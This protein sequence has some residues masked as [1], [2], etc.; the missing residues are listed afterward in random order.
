M[1]HLFLRMVCR[2]CT[3]IFMILSCGNTGSSQTIRHTYRFNDNL[4]VSPPECGPVL[5]PLRSAGNCNAAAGGGAFTDDNV[6]LCGVT[7]KVYQNNLHWGLS[8]PNTNGTITDNYTIQMYVKNISWGSA[9]WSRII[10]FSN[11]SSD[12]GIYYKI[13]SATERCLDFYPSG[14]RGTCP[15]FKLDTYYLLTFTRNGTTGII[16]VYVNNTK[17]VSYPDNS[18]RYVGTS[19]VPILIYRD[20]AAV[21]CESAA[22]NFA[23]LSFST[24]YSSQATVDRDYNGICSIA[25]APDAANFKIEQPDLCNAANDLTV[26]YTGGISSQATGY[27]FNWD[28]HGGTEVSANGF[29]QYVVRYPDKGIKTVTLN[30]RN[31]PCGTTESKSQ[32]FEIKDGK[33]TTSVSQT[34]CAGTSY[35][36]YNSSGIY[37]DSFKTTGGC[38]SIRV[39]TLTALS[40]LTTTI[41]STICPGQNVNGYNSS[42]IYTDVFRLANG[43]DSTRILKL[44]VINPGTTSLGPDRSICIGDTI[45]LSANI[46]GKFEWQDGSTGNNFIVSKPGT[47]WL[48]VTTPCGTSRD[49]VMISES[50]CVTAFP[51]GFTPNGD[52]KNDVFRMVNPGNP[53]SFLLQIYN[54]WG[55]KV[56]ETTDA[57][58]G[59]NG[60]TNGHDPSPGTYVYYCS[61]QLNGTRRD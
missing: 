40:S 19:G 25:N 59:W 20:D 53:Q 31:A 56:F 11:G 38:D 43:C 21:T 42:G 61:V 32:Q 36:G 18:N 9:T 15:F 10:D 51:S 13:S 54:R 44:L 14:V 58:K 23:Y 17:F 29:G 34:I 1:T 39:L 27:L 6:G 52:G 37:T 30:V 57:Y 16:D 26:T 3:I 48:E 12:D 35:E 33:V 22:A 28:W 55:Q 5:T 24:E 60:R 50:S 7:R 4:E 41:D 8:Y 2:V 49:E 45:L 46:S 47:Y